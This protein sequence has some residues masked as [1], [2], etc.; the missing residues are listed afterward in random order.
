M[1]DRQKGL[2]LAYE[3]QFL[4]VD[5][6]YCCRHI[7]NN[8]KSSFPGLLLSNNLWIAAKSYNEKKFNEAIE[9]IKHLNIEAWKFLCKI[10]KNTWARH[11]FNI[12]VKCDHVTNNFTE[13]FN[14]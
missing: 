9:R 13:S 1:S 14:A 7:Y 6:R 4:S 11:A 5:A 10:P 12:E 8:F 3:E 2:N